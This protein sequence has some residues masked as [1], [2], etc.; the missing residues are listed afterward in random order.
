MADFLT[1][2]LNE[3]FIFLQYLFDNVNAIHV[4]VM[5]RLDADYHLTESTNKEIL[6]RWFRITVRTQYN[7]V[8]PTVEKFVGDIGR[9]KMVAPIYL[10]LVQTGEK[11]T[12]QMFFDKY[13]EFYHPLTLKTIQNILNQQ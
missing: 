9:I 8:L 5:K 13:K 7:D 6:W 2:S 3:K 11:N 1:Y 12:A 10:A 4:N